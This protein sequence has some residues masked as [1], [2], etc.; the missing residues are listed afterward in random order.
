M[1][2]VLKEMKDGLDAVRRK[3]EELTHKV[4]QNQLP[5][6][7]GMTYLETKH[8]L[9]LGYCQSIVY[10]LLRKAQGLSIDGHPV[11]RSLVE[12][13]LF[14]EKIRPI[15]KK[16]DYQIQRLT[17]AASAPEKIA[18]GVEDEPK[19]EDGDH[20][21]YRPNP[22]ML[23]PKV[24]P[25]AGKDDVYRPPRFAPT[26]M[27]D[28]KMSKQEK[29]VLRREKELLRRSK[30]SSF[31]KE[32]MDDIEER[33]EELREFVGVE[34]REVSNYIEKRERRDRQEEELFV[35]APITKKDKKLEKHMKRSRGG[36][37]GLTDQFFDEIRTLPLAE[38]ENEDEPSYLSNRNENKSYKK[39]KR[40][41]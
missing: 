7:D 23:I 4:K 9:L 18:S 41:H 17:R 20:L 5:T 30:Q 1:L 3:V 29:Q 24:A 28:D 6:A 11:V 10:Y 27:E 34:N 21:Q 8:L 19:E 40:K 12:I 25:A 33:P 36:L 39:H 26:T 16:M 2:A 37:L 22:D 32:I 13:R 14:L 31:V 15:D 35:R 38:K